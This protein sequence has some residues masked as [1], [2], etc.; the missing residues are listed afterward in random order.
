[1]EFF[2][3]LAIFFF[4]KFLYGVWKIGK[5]GRE[6]LAAIELMIIQLLFCYNIAQKTIRKW[7]ML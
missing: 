2:G 3:F 1:M 7:N 5:E 4:L 6:K